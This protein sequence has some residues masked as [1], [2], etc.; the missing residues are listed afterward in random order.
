MHVVTELMPTALFVH[1]VNVNN[2]N[3]SSDT[4]HTHSIYCDVIPREGSPHNVLH[5]SSNSVDI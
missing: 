5:S 2:Y 1:H 3:K 4:I